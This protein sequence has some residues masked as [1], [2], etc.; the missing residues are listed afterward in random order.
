[1]LDDIHVHGLGN[2]WN[3]EIVTDYDE[4]V[5]W[6]E[7][8]EGSGQVSYSN[9]GSAGNGSGEHTT[10]WSTLTSGQGT[11][12][13]ALPNLHDEGDDDLPDLLSA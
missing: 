4:D 3:A 1:M 6:L 9:I 8:S 7:I 5:L 13:E 11:Y 2:A 12:D 10:L